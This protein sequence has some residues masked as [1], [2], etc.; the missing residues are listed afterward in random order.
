M[1]K[2]EILE[3]IK[4]LYKISELKPEIIIALG[5]AYENLDEQTKT[6]YS[7]ALESFSYKYVAAKSSVSTTLSEGERPKLASPSVITALNTAIH[8]LKDKNIQLELIPALRKAQYDIAETELTV[9]RKAI[10]QGRNEHLDDTQAFASLLNAKNIITKAK[11]SII[12][13]IEL[14][15]IERTLDQAEQDLKDGKISV[16]DFEDIVRVENR[17]KT[18]IAAK[19]QEREYQAEKDAMQLA[20][21]RNYH[22]GKSPS[23]ET[24][25]RWYEVCENC[26]IAKYDVLLA[27]AW[28]QLAEETISQ[29]EARS[30][31]A[32]AVS[33]KKHLQESQN[34]RVAK[35]PEKI[36]TRK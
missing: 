11:N 16:E 25:N 33:M 19:R 10:I 1:T 21:V 22:S 2:E 8:L 7:V 4:E 14:E 35:G 28:L 20:E 30:K 32:Y 34:T 29:S 24:Q 17:R 15:K 13:S 12:S 26:E 9:I 31:I 6:R 18:Y 36:N 23:E 27:E 5:D 3:Q